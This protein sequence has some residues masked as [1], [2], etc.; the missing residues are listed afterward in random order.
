MMKKYYNA[1]FLF[2]ALFSLLA[3][4]ACD[5]DDSGD[6]TPPG[7]LIIKEVIPTN[8]GAKITYT[9][10]SD[11]DV[12][13]VKAKYTNSLGNEVFKVSSYYNDTI[14]LDGFN[15]TLPHN[16]ELYVV[17]RNDNHSIATEVQVK[18]LVSYIYLVQ[19]SIQITP[20]LGG[21]K[22]EWENVSAKT[23]H[24]YVLLKNEAYEDSTIKSSFLP[25]YQTYIRGLDSVNYNFFIKVEDFQGNQTRQ[26]FIA[27]VKP[28]F[29][30]EI[31][32]TSWTLVSGLSANGNAYEGT[33]VA[34]W[35]N[36]IDYKENADD[37]SYF[38]MLRDNNGGAL[39]YPMDIVIDMNKKVVVNRFAVWQRAFYY[40]LRTS[41]GISEV[42]YYYQSENMR[43]F[44]IYTSNNLEEWILAGQFDIGDP[45]DADGN[46]PKE[47]IQEAID[48]HMFVLNNTTEPFRYLKFSITS[49]YG[50]E[51][52]LSGSEITLFGLDNVEK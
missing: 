4:Y 31:D 50:S 26:E 16:V 36:V 23:V 43:K 1:H 10:P 12:L 51:I 45:K 17:D 32:K 19:Q 47:K 2:I 34:F 37:N 27:T 48:G 5:N 46:V 35:D 6:S 29:E 11:E 9:L 18:P 33:T 28:K 13:F 14:E 39:N 15:D 44:D 40:D 3:F 21:V 30:Q 52:Q 22:I 41:D 25:N 49:N 42:P 7:N 20:D 24:V 38:I 8:G